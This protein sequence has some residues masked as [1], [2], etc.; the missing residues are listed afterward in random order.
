VSEPLDHRGDGSDATMNLLRAVP[1]DIVLANHLSQRGVHVALTG[2]GADELFIG[3]SHLF[4]RMP[5]HL[6]QQ[7][8]LTEYFKL[9]LRAMK[10]DDANSAKEAIGPGC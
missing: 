5:K 4:R 3:Y 8:F 10:I 9:D 7:R 1:D 2:S 6:L